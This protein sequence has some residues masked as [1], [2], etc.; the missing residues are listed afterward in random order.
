MNFLRT[1]F[2]AAVACLAAQSTGAGAA[3]DALEISQQAR[4][5]APGEVLALWVTAPPAVTA[6]ASTWRDRAVSF[7]RQA[8]GR[9]HA[10]VGIDLEEAPGERRLRVVGRRPGAAELAA[11]HTFVLEPKQWR[12]RR[13]KVAPRFVDPPASELPRIREESA[14]LGKLFASARSERL[15]QDGFVVPV[16]GVGVSGFGVRSVFNGQPRAPHTGADFAAP[17]GTPIR[18]PAAGV[19]AYARPFYYSGNTV[20]LDHGLG[21]YSTMAHMSAFDVKEGQRVERGALLGKVGATGRVTGPHLHWAVR[22]LGARVDPVS[23]VAATE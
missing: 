23:L 15:W 14:L 9:W 22:L 2:V 13:L 1:L 4:A 18:A 17:T 11:V 21:L 20:I 19:V 8:D 10:L 3:A 12:T 7:V 6:V 16:D 5:V